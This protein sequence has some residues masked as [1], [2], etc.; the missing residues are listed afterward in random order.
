MKGDDP[1][2]TRCHRCGR[3]C[4]TW[5]GNRYVFGSICDRADC[6]RVKEAL[7]PRFREWN[8]RVSLPGDGYAGQSA[9]W[10][11]DGSVKRHE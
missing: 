2:T 7:A 1:A 5:W 10:N 11:A 3:A 6:R 9:M 4:R 8:M